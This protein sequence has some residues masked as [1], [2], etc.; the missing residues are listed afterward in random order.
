M[1]DNKRYYYLKLKD[2]FYDDDR[3]KIIESMENGIYY[4]N[5]LLKLYLKSLKTDGSLRFTNTIPY[6][7]KLISTITNL[8]IDFVKCGLKILIETGF[9]EKLDDGTLFMSEIQNYIG[10]SST[11]ADRKRDYRERIEQN[12]QQLLPES[13]ESGTNVRTK[14]GHEKDI[15]PPEIEK[16]LEL[17]LEIEK[18]KEPLEP[19]DEPKHKPTPYQ[20]IEELYHKLCP[21]FNKIKKL[22]DTRKDTLKGWYREGGIEEIETVFMK[23]NESSFLKGKNDRKWVADFDWIIKPANRLKVLEDK[24]KDKGSD[25]AGINTRNTKPTTKPPKGFD[26]D[27]FK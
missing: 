20:K 24:Y 2:N 3:I 18:E 21:N 9:I 10:K 13:N 14:A 11:E 1:A 4:S 27:E 8:N 12:K 15:S 26:P 16:E 17:D 25:T 6:N 22:S 7:E 23:A 19:P 5:L